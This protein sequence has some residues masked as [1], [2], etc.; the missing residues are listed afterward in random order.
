MDFSL[1]DDQQSLRDLATRMFREHGQPERLAELEQGDWFDRQLWRNLADAGLLGIAVDEQHGGA[2]M[3]LLEL[4]LLL[5][6]LGRTVAHVP[7]WE[8]AYAALAIEQ[9]GTSLDLL[10]DV[11]AGEVVPTV[12]LQD[13]GA[14]PAAPTTTA[15]AADGG[16]ALTGTKILVPAAQVA[17]L[18]VVSA[19]TDAGQTGL[20]LVQCTDVVMLPH[21]LSSDIPHAQVTMD[22]APAIALGEPDGTAL[23]VLLEAAVAGQASVQTGLCEAALA[24]AAKYTASREQFGR[25]IATFQAVSQRVADAFIDTECLRLTA[26]QA[27]WRLAEGLPATDEVRIAG[28]WAAEA[29]H[30]VLHACHHVH[31]GI[32][33]D[34]DY[35]LYRYLMRTKQHEFTLGSATD[36][37]VDLGLALAADPA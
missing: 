32:G 22:G 11:C 29:G 36:H 26:L 34:R 16:W 15:V 18:L 25:P 21:R 10:A 12:A 20:F 9:S 23:P 24:L 37:L 14:T 13:E 8:T 1:T 27:A 33:V 3:T 28:Y 7:L 30:R 35:P 31:G 19:T 2:G 5:V 17:D 4:H 6:E